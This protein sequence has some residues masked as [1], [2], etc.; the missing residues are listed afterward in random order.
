MNFLLFMLAQIRVSHLQAFKKQAFG[1]N[2]LK[3]GVQR[4]A[5]EQAFGPTVGLSDG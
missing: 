5:S 1:K 4:R 2:A 3:P